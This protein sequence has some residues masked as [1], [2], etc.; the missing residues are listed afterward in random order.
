MYDIIVV[1]AGINGGLIAYEL[2]KY[3][4]KVA[5]LEK[6][7]DVGNEATAANS[8]IVHSGHDPKPNTLKAKLN[9]R[10][11]ELFEDLCNELKVDFIRNGAL[12]VATDESELPKL[13]EL[14]EQALERKVPV[15]MI[16]REEAIR[17]EPN[18]SD[19]VMKALDLPSTGIISPWEV[20][21]AA[22]ESAVDNGVELFLNNKVV[23]VEK[24]EGYFN[25][26]TNKSTYQTKIVINS[27]GLYSDDIYRMV[28]NQSSYRIQARRGEYY[29]LDRAEKPVVSRTIYPLP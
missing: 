21:I 5:V 1:G 22:M 9:V 2:S 15:R 27:A 6:D 10:G 4:L 25:I 17:L 16:D 28:S 19:T 3:N 13:N 8:A 18:L 24:R 20:T 23:N 14:Y 7:N 12:V 26:E 29:V 11:N